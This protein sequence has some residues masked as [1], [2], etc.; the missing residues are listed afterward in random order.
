MVCGLRTLLLVVNL[1]VGQNLNFREVTRLEH[2]RLL[3]ESV[4][5]AEGVPNPWILLGQLS[6]VILI[7]FLAD[8]AVT[9]WRRG[10]RH[11]ALAVGGSIV[12]YMLVS[13]DQSLLA[14]ANLSYDHRGA[15]GPDLGGRTRA[16]VASFRITLPI[17]EEGVGK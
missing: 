4:A 14:F 16:R 15:S 9:A 3:G 1:L 8:A 12:F 7:I 5:I 6:L 10:D 17:A 13:T 2:M 11:H